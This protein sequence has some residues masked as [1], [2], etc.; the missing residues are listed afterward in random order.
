[1]N[2]SVNGSE[3]AIIVDTGQTVDA[4]ADYTAPAPLPAG[5]LI[6]ESWKYGN[7]AAGVFVL[8]LLLRDVLCIFWVSGVSFRAQRRSAQAAESGTDG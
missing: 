8:D 3:R 4:Q 1:M 7:P 6:E 5:T 2:A